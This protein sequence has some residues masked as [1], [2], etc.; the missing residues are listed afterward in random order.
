[1]NM[2]FKWTRTNIMT[3]SNREISRIFYLFEGFYNYLEENVREKL[4]GNEVERVF[5]MSFRE[6]RTQMI[7][8]LFDDFKKRCLV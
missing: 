3:L 1:M 4:I 6:V 7:L 5:E 2:K 8:F